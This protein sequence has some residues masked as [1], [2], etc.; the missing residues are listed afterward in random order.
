MRVE[1]KVLVILLLTILFIPES[2]EALHDMREN[3]T[4][5]GSFSTNE[6][7]SAEFYHNYLFIADT[8]SLL[9]FNTSNPE[10]LRLVTTYREFSEPGRVY[11]LSISEDLL[12]IASGAGW[13][14]VLNI[15]N[16]EKPEKLYQ[17]NYLGNANDVSFNGRY[18]YVADTNTGLLIF[19]MT[20]RRQPELT[21]MFYVLKSNISG[22]LQGWGGESVA[23]SGGYAFLRGSQRKGFYIIDVSD[24][25]N[26]KEVFHS[27]GKE[28]YDI[29]VSGNNVY[30][31]RADGTAQFDVLDIS[32]PY[33]PE[34]TG[35]FF[36]FETAR[37]SAIAVH[38]SGDYIY[39]ASGNT[40]HIFK[41][42]DNIPPRV[43][44]E[45]PDEGE[46]F[47]N[48]VINVSGDA[49][50]RSGIREVLVNGKFAGTESW[51]QII[52]LVNGTNQINITVYD[53]N[54][55]SI[56][57]IIEVVYRPP[58]TTPAKPD[59]ITPAETGLKQ[60]GYALNL[61]FYGFLAIIAI[62][63]IWIYMKKRRG[64]SIIS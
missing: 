58:I 63:G 37:R 3:M 42:K 35:S 22:S 7:R 9:V 21:G 15:S 25:A 23:V 33:N 8:N 39:A 45:R 62:I 46:I 54:G 30:L 20:I 57:E 36:I 13:I 38:P 47:T 51:N 19:D 11:G 12:Y 10:S 64:K 16:P 41:I 32:N 2:V 59:E 52:E 17:L 55:N 4:E 61:V 24:P 43:I 28:I 44:I 18:M 14:Y 49:F 5:V 34:I 1:F 48:Q 26:P 56:S 27:I 50:D 60:N 53:N 6:P 29:A 31:A 40:W